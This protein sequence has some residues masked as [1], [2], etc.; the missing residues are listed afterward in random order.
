VP[1]E[2]LGLN[3]PDV[4]AARAYFDVFLPMV[5][6]VR[7]WE[8]GY[9]PTDWKGAQLFI[10]PALEEGEHSRLRTGLSHISFLV[11]TRA[12]VNRVYEWVVERGDEVLHSPRV[13]PEYGETFYATFFLDPHGFHLEVV[14]FEKV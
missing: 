11:G 12:E 9:R 5:G 14:T 10:Y 8:A 2:H 1:I 3:V 4:E 7:E 6:Y 13:F